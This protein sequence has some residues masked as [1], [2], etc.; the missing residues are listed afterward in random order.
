MAN[1]RETVT[2]AL[3]PEASLA[4]I[5]SAIHVLTS[6][7]EQGYRGN[8][9]AL[10]EYQWLV[11]D[12]A[13]ADDES[14]S[15]TRRF[16]ARQA[17]AVEE[18]FIAP[19][20]DFKPRSESE[21][22]RHLEGLIANHSRVQHPMSRYLFENHGTLEQIKIFLQHQWLRTFKLYRDASDFVL[23]LTDVEDAA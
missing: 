20:E 8:E 4:Q 10:S 6:L 17:H 11:Y 15:E 3:Q 9:S 19:V 13:L 16:I 5:E 21:F 7:A 18:K 1:N 2:Q 23:R 22:Y 14:N 12:V